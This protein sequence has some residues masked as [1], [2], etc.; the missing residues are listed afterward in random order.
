VHS[1]RGGKTTEWNPRR[2][3]LLRIQPRTRAAH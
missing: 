2:H 3:A 1:P